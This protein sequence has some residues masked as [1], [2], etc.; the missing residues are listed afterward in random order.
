MADEQLDLRQVEIAPAAAEAALSPYGRAVLKVL[1]AI[2][3]EDG[4]VLEDEYRWYLETGAKLLVPHWQQ[5][6]VQVLALRIFLEPPS[7]EDALRELEASVAPG[8]VSAELR[9]KVSEAVLE[10][11]ESAPQAGIKRGEVAEQLIRATGDD[12]PE[13]LGRA[14]ALRQADRAYEGAGGSTSVRGLPRRGTSGSL[15]SRVFGRG[16]QGTWIEPRIREINAGFRH[17]CGR[18]AWLGEILGRQGLVDAARQV[19]GLLEDRPYRIVLVGEFKHGKSCLFNAIAGER[20]SPAGET[21]PTTAAVV[22][23]RHSERPSYEGR[24]LD[25]ERLGALREYL[26]AD[27]GNVYAQEAGEALES[28]C[29]QQWFEPGG[30]LPLCPTLE[31]LRPFLEVTGEYAIAVERVTVGLPVD[32]LRSGAVLIDTPGLNDPSRVRELIAVEEARKADCAVFVLHGAKLGSES[33]RRALGEIL[34]TG[35]ALHV[36]P[37][38]THLDLLSSLEAQDLALEEARK[39]VEACAPDG[40]AITLLPPLGINAAYAAKRGSSRSGKEAP[41][42]SELGRLQAALREAMRDPGRTEQYEQ[43]LTTAISELRTRSLESAA[44]WLEEHRARLPSVEQLSGQQD[45][46]EKLRQTGEHYRRHISRRLAL[47]RE[48]LEAQD[49][50]VAEQIEAV[51]QDVMAAM[52]PAMEA[53]IVKLGAR[54]GNRKAWQELDERLSAEVVEPRLERFRAEQDRS[55][56]GWQSELVTFEDGLRGEVEEALES[57]RVSLDEIGSLALEQD[58]ILGMKL[59][60]REVL[61][62][63]MRQLAA[64]GIGGLLVDGSATLAA[65]VKIA[66]TLLSGTGTMIAVG[67]GATLAASLKL[68][69]KDAARQRFLDKK[70]EGAE[71]GL[72]EHLEGVVVQRRRA[73]QEIWERFYEIADTYYGPVIAGAFAV[74]ERVRLQ[75]RIWDKIRQDGEQL[76]G[77]LTRGELGIAAEGD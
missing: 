70:L 33:E 43:R 74:A 44:K 58:R 54:L 10:L 28:I 20:L 64:A 8:R 38:V 18:A 6:P 75:H 29:R 17:V 60:A 5:V 42:S 45:L 61:D 1:A 48:R 13:R 65:G 72:T 57:L 16:D 46:A 63:V 27:R 7:L 76:V 24:W 50:E 31:D 73:A 77:S 69:D 14:R 71:R 9:A 11:L 25:R 51:K 62:T 53:E 55:L 15:F 30:E 35:R 2:S 3:A 23:L 21:R 32:A 37:V 12:S 49:A 52:R 56:E 36:L 26:E 22:E 34:R 68:M 59:A 66:V 41:A 19:E 39:L 67:V 40:G 4:A 47:I